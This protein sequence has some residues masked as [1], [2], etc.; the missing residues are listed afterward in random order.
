MHNLVTL[1][2]D[3]LTIVD[4]L[5]LLVIALVANKWWTRILSLSAAFGTFKV[6]AFVYNH[7]GSGWA[8]E[9]SLGVFLA[10]VITSIAT[11]E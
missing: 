11:G 2:A 1:A 10:I 4:L 9:A 6:S 8:L 7:Y 3:V 5:A